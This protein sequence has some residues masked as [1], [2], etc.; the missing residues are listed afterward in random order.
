LNIANEILQANI[1]IIDDEPANVKLLKKLLE[2]QGYQN[3]SGTS[4]PR[5]VESL[6]AATE[7]DAFLL[8]IRMPYLDGYGIMTLLKDKFVNDYMPV[9]V[10]TAQTDRETRLKAL[11]YG[12][13][14]FLTKPFD[15]LEALTRIHN[16]LEVRLMHKHIRDQNI[17]LEEQVQQR[18]QE[19]YDTRHEVIARLGMAAEYRDNETGNHIIRMSK[20]A[21][22]LALEIGLGEGHADIIL[23]AAPMHDIGK[24]G[25][26]DSVLLKPGKLDAEEWQIMRSH[27]D[28]GAKILSGHDSEL[29]QAACLIALHHHEK[30]NGSGYPAGLKGEQISIEGRI[31]AVADVFDA[32]LSVRPYKKPWTVEQA[33]SLIE[34]EAGQHF[35]PNIAPLMRKLLP[36][37]M[38][39]MQQYPDDPI[40]S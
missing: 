12:A 13:K 23:N 37:A 4:D 2:R 9:L 29:M 5:D 26:P 35:D 14:D 33:L 11:K 19:L 22:L 36:A 38:E 7:F 1:L 16:L 24:I 39:I 8:D 28:I 3:V 31:C 32:L 40:T 15:Q 6:C 25:I 18:T 27:V 21:K 30:W 20:Y 34:A 10:L 17:I